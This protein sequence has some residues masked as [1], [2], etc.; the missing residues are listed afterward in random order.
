[1]MAWLQR[2]LGKKRDEATRVDNIARDKAEA[3]R[4]LYEAEIRLKMLEAEADVIRRKQ[5]GHP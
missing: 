3:A 5:R 2:L 1:M 4:R